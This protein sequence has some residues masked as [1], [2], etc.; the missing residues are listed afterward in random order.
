MLSDYHSRGAFVTLRRVL[1]AL[2]LRNIHRNLRR[3]LP[4]LGIL[5]VVFLLLVVG[6]ALLAYSGAALY[7]T[8]ATHVA[9]DLSLSA[10]G[11]QSFTIFGS[12]ALLVGEYLVPGVIGDFGQ[13]EAAATAMPEVRATAGVVSALARV[14]VGDTRM[15][16]LMG[17]DFGAYRA[18]FPALG[19]VAGRWPEAGERAVVL[20]ESWGESVLGQRALLAVAHSASFTLREVPVTGLFRYPVRDEQL[21]R[22]ALVDPDTARALN[23]HVYGT[24]ARAAVNGDKLDL[25][26]S[27]LDDLFAV[28][29]EAEVSTEAVDINEVEAFFADLTAA[30]AAR[31][32]MEGAWNFLLVALH[33]RADGPLVRRALERAAG[34]G[35]VGGVLV[36]DWRATVGGTAQLGWFLQLLLNLGLFFVALGAA[37][38]VTNALVLA[39]LERTREIGTMRALGATRGFIAALIA[40]ETIVVVI[41]GAI[42]GVLLGVV[43]LHTIEAAEVVVSNRYLLI[44][45]GGGA[46]RGALSGA[47]VVAHFGAAAVLAALAVIYPLKRAL[48]ISPTKAMS[49]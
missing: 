38:I 24:V 30:E 6:N 25:L 28:A 14:T 44:L 37:A 36:R 20:P 17:V 11:A 2:V 8:Y 48:G 13:L 10:R 7:R 19:L 27:D 5:S 26:D 49:Q 35:S 47:L 15:H 34:G 33:D 4:M 12:E 39:V 22:V 41:G 31:T 21:D 3:L 29:D 16:S 9:G 32:T 1:P 45:F 18:F 42:A 46:L 40:A 43:A 23:G